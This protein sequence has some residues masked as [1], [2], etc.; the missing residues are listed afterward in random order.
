MGLTHLPHGLIAT[1]NL[2]GTGRLMDMFN[3]DNIWFVDAVNGSS[4]NTGKEPTKALALPSQ[5][6]SKASHGA[7]IYIKPYLV[8]QSVTSSSVYYTDDIIIPYE[9]AGISLIGCGLP[10]PNNYGGVGLRPST[11]TGTLVTIKSSGNT[12]ENLC[13]TLNGGTADQGQSI[14]NS[15]RNN[16]AGSYSRSYSGLIRNCRFT[17]DKSHPSP[18]T[19]YPGCISLNCAVNYIIEDCIFDSC[20]NALMMQSVVGNAEQV[21]FQRNIVGGLCS[22]RDVDIYLSINSADCNGIVIRDNV[23]ADGKPTHNTGFFIYMPYVTAGTG[24]FANNYFATKTATNGFKEG[25]T[26]TEGNVADNFFFAGN[27]IEGTATTDPMN[28]GTRAG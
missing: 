3:S 18:A 16:T 4:G 6:I 1:P 12:L 24:I 11:V 17:E 26:A 25:A 8:D 10:C 5:A 7:A 9:K 22:A 28:Q 20:L 15:T 21:V 2:G 19:P 27:W 13:L 14:V 23:F